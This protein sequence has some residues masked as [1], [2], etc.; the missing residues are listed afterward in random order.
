MKT[1]TPYVEYLAV[2][3]SHAY[4]T[5]QPTSDIDIRGI[6]IPPKEYQLCFD[7]HFEQYDAIHT[8]ENYPFGNLIKRYADSHTIQYKQE[9]KVDQCIYDLKKFFSLAAACNPNVIEILYVDDPEVLISTRIGQTLRFNKDKFLSARAKFTYSGYAFS[10]LKRIH[11]HRKYLLNPPKS[12]PERFEYGLPPVSTISA[13]Q[14]DAAEKLIDDKV[15]EWLFM[16]AEVDKTVQAMV[17]DKLK[18]FLASIMASSNLIMDLSDENKLRDAAR[19]AAMQ[20]QGFD[21]NYIAIVQAEKKYRSALN[22][23]KQY[24]DWKINRNKERAKLEENWGFDL[25][26]ASHLVRLL[27]TCKE[28]LTEGIVRV[29]R[30]D[31]QLLLDIRHGAWSYEQLIAFAEKMEKELDEIYKNKTYVVPKIPDMNYLSWLCFDLLSS[32]KE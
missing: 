29:K 18:D 4:G 28:I 32:R 31:A 21:K 7:K 14:R 19:L 26:H 12:K 5:A 25:K 24:Q 8:I 30:P 22:E 3:G 17:H 20:T 11:C 2:V 15:R 16:D 13:D 10:Q 27:L 1:I 6:A 9:D 23:W